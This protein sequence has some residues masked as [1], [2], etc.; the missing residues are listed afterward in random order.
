M[1]ND[2]ASAAVI[3]S[4]VQDWGFAR[5]QGRWEALEA[6]FH[7]DGEIAVSWFRGPYAEFVAHCRRNHGRGSTAKHL[8]WPSRV[9]VNRDR[10]TAETNV[11]IL[12]RQTIEGVEVDL[13][14]QGRFLDRVERRDG[15]WRIVERAALYEKDRLDPVEPSARFDALMASADAAK[16][17]SSYRYMAYR[18]HAA[19]RSL[20]EPVHY[21]GRPETEAMKA[22][23]AA[24][25][26]GR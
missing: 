23:Y 20:A 25:L 19:G 4:L 14:S 5:D 22:R 24:W 11:A 9:A 13:T 6:I 3:Q 7:P 2:I 18:V 21:D 1:S 8:L 17:P 16:Y 26:D 10:A 12:V 15:N